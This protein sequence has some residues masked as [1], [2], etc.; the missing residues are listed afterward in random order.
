MK[1]KCASYVISV[2][3]V[4]ISTF[5]IMVVSAYYVSK[6]KCNAEWKDSGYTY[7]YGMLSGCLIKTKEGF[8][9][10]ANTVRLNKEK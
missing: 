1:T 9:L 3:V 10:P 7:E 6:A 5:T 8:W 4:M 2:I